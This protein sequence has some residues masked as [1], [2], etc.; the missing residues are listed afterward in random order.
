[1]RTHIS[2]AQALPQKS[3]IKT[4]WYWYERGVCVCKRIKKPEIKP[5]IHLWSIDFW[6]GYQEKFFQ[7]VVLGQPD[8][9][10]QKKLD[11]CF[12]AYIKI[13][14]K[15]VDL[16]VRARSIKLWGK[17]KS[18]NVYLYDSVR[19]WFSRYDI[20]STRDQ[21]INW[22]HRHFFLILF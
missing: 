4:I 15:C 10:M 2:W 19:Q 14:S 20:K 7:Q 6:Q 1:M 12:T 16:T 18:I 13:N 5:P 11:S 22:H 8:I 17:K 9:H 3:V 21:M